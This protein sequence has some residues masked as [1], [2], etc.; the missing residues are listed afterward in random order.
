MATRSTI[1][2]ELP[3]GEI[4]QIYC[5][6][7]GY[8]DNNGAI[9]AQHYTDPV[10]VVKLIALGDL[11]SLGPELGKKRPFGNPHKYG[12]DAYNEFNKLYENQCLVYGRDRGEAD[13]EARVFRDWADFEKN[14]QAEQYN[15]VF[16]NGQ[17][18]VSDD[19]GCSWASL[20]RVV[21]LLNETESA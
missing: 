12:T 13:T 4:R 19:D 17:W 3:S 6:Y 7:D 21:E 15:Y 9:L 8:I 16:R 18:S 11:S 2:M 14:M 20:N 1:A 5:H 10:K